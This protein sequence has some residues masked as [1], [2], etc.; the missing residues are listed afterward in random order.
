MWGRKERVGVSQRISRFFGLSCAV[1]SFPSLSK[2]KKKGVIFCC[3]VKLSLPQ[4]TRSKGCNYSEK[5]VCFC[6][7]RFLTYVNKVQTK[8]ICGIENRQV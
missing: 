5:S 1:S 8:L 7:F 6:S 2:Q 3:M 4:I